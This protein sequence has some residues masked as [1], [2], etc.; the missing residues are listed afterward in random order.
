M[1]DKSIKFRVFSNG[2]MFSVIKLEWDKKGIKAYTDEFT[3]CRPKDLM[4]STGI[5]DINGV[6]IYS[7]DIVETHSGLDNS[8]YI[9][10]VKK[11]NDRPEISFVPISGFILC[12]PNKKYFQVIGNI[13]QNSEL[14]ENK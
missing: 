4:I 12:E 6:E 1:K 8:S 5:Y 7:G 13:Y 11:L 9:R 3:F 10:E 2:K 14:L